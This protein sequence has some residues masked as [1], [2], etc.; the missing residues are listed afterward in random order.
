VRAVWG[1]PLASKKLSENPVISHCHSGLDPNPRRDGVDWIPVCTGMTISD[2]PS[3]VQ[4]T[5]HQSFLGRKCRHEKGEAQNFPDELNEVIYNRFTD[6]QT[7]HCP[8]R[9]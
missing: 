9:L 4:M 3:R 7:S 8:T 5:L 6:R 2:R 1:C